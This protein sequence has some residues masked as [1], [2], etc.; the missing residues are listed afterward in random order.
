MK[1]TGYVEEFDDKEAYLFARPDDDGPEEA[2]IVGLDRLPAY[3]LKRG[4]VWE[5]EID[6]KNG[7]VRWTFDFSFWTEEQIGA[8]KKEAKRLQERFGIPS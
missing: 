2:W 5:L 8:V 1:F 6:P 7:V 3:W 4:A